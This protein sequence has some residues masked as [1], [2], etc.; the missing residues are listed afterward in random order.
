M[1]RVFRIALCAMVMSACTDR[2]EQ[3]VGTQ[4][5]H[6]TQYVNP[7]IG[8]G[9][10]GHTFPG[11]T[12]PFGMVQLSPDTRTQGWDACGGYH[13]S[14]STILGFSH[15]HLSG[16][17]IAD[18]GDVLFMPFSGKGTVRPGTVEDSD[19]GYRSRF[20]H[21]QETA[22]PGYYAVTLLD[23]NIDVELTATLRAGFHRYHFPKDSAKGV[24]IDLAHTLQRHRNSVNEIR[25]ISDTEIAGL[26]VTHGWAREHHVYFYAKFNKPFEAE[27]YVDRKK[28]DGTEI[29]S[30]SGQA[31]LTFDHDDDT[32][33]LTK[34]G[35]SSVDC[36]GAKANLFQ[37]IPDWDFDRVKTAAAETWNAQ[38]S[39][40]VVQGGSEE[41]KT[42]FYTALYHASI[43]PSL[44]NDVDG[45]Y[46]G[47]DHETHTIDGSPEYTVF[48]L[49]DTFR[50]FHPLLTII[51]PQRNEEFIRSL[52]TKYKQGGVLPK[53]ELAANYTGTMIGDH[54]ISVIYD[55]YKKGSRD[56]DVE[57]AY[58]AMKEATA[59][60]TAGILAPNQAVLT[61]LKPMAKYYNETL[62]FIPAD[63]EN[64]SVSKALE[65]AYNDWCVA[66]MARDLGKNED[67]EVYMARAKRYLEYF[68]RSTGF[69]RGKNRDGNWREPFHPRFS[70]H[71]ND[72]YT[73][74]NAW[75]WTWFVPHDVPG[76]VELMGGVDGFRAKLDSLFTT[77]SEILGEHASNDI[78]GL[79][80]Q[81]AH[82]N[83]PSHH[84]THLYNFI[85]EPWKTQ[86]LADT[87]M[88]ALY[89][90]EPDGLSGNEDCG[91]M[92]A[93]YIMN[94][95][96]FYSFCPGNP[97]YTIGRPLFDEVTLDL[98]NGNRF[99]I[100]TINNSRENKYI[101]S[102]KLNAA[103]LD[104]PFFSHQEILDGGVLEFV[105]GPEPNRSWGTFDV[106]EPETVASISPED[107]LQ[108]K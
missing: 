20:S 36:E 61:R 48:S 99:V 86:Y 17:G 106:T 35:I 84:V 89:T 102:A 66:Q 103:D 33:I 88:N 55:A 4:A 11:A 5:D 58:R 105:M 107:R 10:H 53:W 63:L 54:A 38:L 100:R 80:G 31:I 15:T 92:S 108:T 68:D 90:N 32:P 42:V 83:E 45:R 74:G 6:L 2:G 96:G 34:V 81:Y 9:G 78:S 95:M 37:E 21:E 47:M 82:G 85:G 75:Q 40:I 27:L 51:D 8:T 57:L 60:D 49:W 101:Q 28:V 14:D 41:Q 12:L 50:A 18:Y 70:K 56:F 23:E 44:F 26:K 25:V 64:E 13:Y 52:L 73:E 65:F 22:S 71:R 43:S 7:F 87:I 29:N 97:E 46:R 39:K 104:R 69:M 91:Q 72:D 3:D 93:W 59:Y 62:G 30:T 77:T 19:A 94:A 1:K 24:V 67:Y 79:I 76:L 98:Q 16:T